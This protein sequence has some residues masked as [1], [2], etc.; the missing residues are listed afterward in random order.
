MVR[1][2]SDRL[3]TMPQME[4]KSRR[5]SLANPA[6]GRIGAP[7]SPAPLGLET[8]LADDRRQ[9]LP[10]HHPIYP[11]ARASLEW[12]DTWS[13]TQHRDQMAAL[14]AAWPQQRGQHPLRQTHG[15]GAH[16]LRRAGASIQEIAATLALDADTLR[17]RDTFEE[18][19][20]IWRDQIE[21]PRQLAAEHGPLPPLP[22]V[23]DVRR[24]QPPTFTW[25]NLPLAS[26]RRSREAVAIE[27]RVSAK[28]AEMRGEQFGYETRR[29]SSSAR[30][31]PGG[32]LERGLVSGL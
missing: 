10:L 32:S 9:H 17:R 28:L 16:V 26:M 25:V 1:R 19:E 30:S 8:G 6:Y 2:P 5:Q 29:S 18:G 13:N 11:F 4:M 21:Q 7:E 3:D 22:R 24:E 20:A 12:Q 23:Y 15:W 14:V 27:Y 31:G